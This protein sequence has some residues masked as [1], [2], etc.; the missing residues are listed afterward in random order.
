MKAGF[1]L[2]HFPEVNQVST[3]NNVITA[4]LVCAYSV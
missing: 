4:V 2:N 1:K 3:S